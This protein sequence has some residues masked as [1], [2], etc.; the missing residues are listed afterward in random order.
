MHGHASWHVQYAKLPEHIPSPP[1]LLYLQIPAIEKEY[2]RDPQN[3][4]IEVVENTITNKSLDIVITDNNEDY[5]GWGV[6]FKIQKKVDS[7]WKDL[8]FKSDD[9]AWIAIAYLPDENN[10]LKQTIDIEEYY[11]KLKK[12]IYRVVKSVYDKGYIDIYSNEFEIK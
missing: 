6:D 5:Y 9:I 10:K 12:G 1:H 8:K 4:T 11:G 3:V 2:N 7:E